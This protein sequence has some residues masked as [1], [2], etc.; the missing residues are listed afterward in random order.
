MSAIQGFPFSHVSVTHLNLGPVFWKLE[1]KPTFET[2]H[3][4][5]I[6]NKFSTNRTFIIYGIA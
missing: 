6:F 5:E 4:L 1:H 2:I 3:N